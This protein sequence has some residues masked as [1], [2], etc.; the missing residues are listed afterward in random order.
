MK[1]QK[2]L[3]IILAVIC[4]VVVCLCPEL[5]ARAD[6]CHNQVSSLQ[7][8]MK[9][10]RKNKQK[11][12]Q[13]QVRI[14]LHKLL[15]KKCRKAEIAA[16][17]GLWSLQAKAPDQAVNFYTLAIELSSKSSSELAR[18]REQREQAATMM[19]FRLDSHFSKPRTLQPL[20]PH[21]A[22]SKRVIKKRDFVFV[23]LSMQILFAYNSHRIPSTGQYLLKIIAES[24]Q[25]YIKRGHRYRIVGHTCDVGNSKRNLKLSENRAKEVADKLSELLKQK[26]ALRGNHFIVEGKGYEQPLMRSTS[27]LARNKNRRV[28]IVQ[29]K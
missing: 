5:D 26:Y 10:A 25:K 7:K 28:E 1:Q 14:K 27:D 9:V 22:T 4:C 6:Y 3:T 19:H 13:E 11:D 12:T 15:E 23:P 16:L 17:A 8:Q 20:K 29:I 18:Y 2:F 21:K 24:I